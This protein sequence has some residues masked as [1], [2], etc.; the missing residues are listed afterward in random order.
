MGVSTKTIR[1]YESAGVLE[2]AA[3]QPNGYRDYD[4]VAVARLEFVQAGQAIGLSLAELRTLVSLRADGRAPCTEA[5]D[6]LRQHLSEI[7]ERLKV[8][9]V[10][11]REVGALLQRAEALDPA[12][13]DPASVCHLINPASCP[14]TSHG[15]RR[16]SRAVSPRRP[17]RR[18]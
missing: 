14:C 15:E 2:P 11:H 9:R 1:F 8:L 3:R 16:V 10:L 17:T 4:D 18:T 13:C 5:R 12:D 7:N 6:I